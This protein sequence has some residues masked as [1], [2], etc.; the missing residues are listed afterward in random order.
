VPLDAI[1]HS[2]IQTFLNEQDIVLSERQWLPCHLEKVILIPLRLHDTGL[3]VPADSLQNMRDLVDQHVRQKVAHS[4]MI[5]VDPVVQHLNV[6]PLCKPH[7]AGMVVLGGV[8]I[9]ADHNSR[10]LARRAGAKTVVPLDAYTDLRKHPGRDCLRPNHVVIRFRLH[11]DHHLSFL[12]LP[13]FP[14]LG[15]HSGHR[16]YRDHRHDFHVFLPPPG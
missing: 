4:G 1:R 16:C 5:P 13:G 8:S 3:R 2:R 7:R 9:Q 15:A 10:F 6:V 12:R 11:T 14:R